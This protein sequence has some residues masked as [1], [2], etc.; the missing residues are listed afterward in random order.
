MAIDRRVPKGNEAAMRVAPVVQSPTLAHA[1]AHHDE[2]LTVQTILAT[3]KA[4]GAPKANMVRKAMRPATVLHLQARAGN[5]A[6]GNL[7][8]QRAAEPKVSAED[9]KSVEGDTDRSEFTDLPAKADSELAKVPPK[10]DKPPPKVI[11]PPKPK[12]PAVKGKKKTRRPTKGPRS[13]PKGRRGSAGKKAPRKGAGLVGKRAPPLPPKYNF[14][15][16]LPAGP[17]GVPIPYPAIANPAFKKVLGKNRRAVKGAHKHPSGKQESANAQG[18]ALAPAND[19]QAQAK[20]SHATTM[21]TAKPKPFDE[22]AFV[23]AVEAAITRAAPRNLAEAGKLDK[24]AAGMKQA[25]SGTVTSAK[26][27]AAGDVD[28]KA[29]RPLDPSKAIKKPVEPL[30]PLQIPKPGPLGAAAAMPPPVSNEMVDMRHGPATVDQNMADA[31]VDEKQLAESNEPEFAGA[32]D[33]KKEATKH[34]DEAPAKIRAAEAKELKKAQSG[35]SAAERAALGKAGAKIGAV[36]GGVGGKKTDAKSKDE[37]ARKKVADT[38]NSIYD[39]TKVDV[40]KVLSGLSTKV[41][42]QFTVGEARVRAMFTSDWKRRLG[43]YKSRRYSGIR[44]KYRWVRDKFKGLPAAANDLFEKSRQI[45]E[46]QMKKLVRQMAKIVSAELQRA[47]ARIEAGRKQISDYVGSLKGDLAKVGQEAAA[48]IAEKFDDLDSSVKDTFDDLANDLGKKYAE[49]RDAV[50]AEIT[51]A[52]EENKG[53]IDKAIDKVKGAIDTIRKLKDMLLNVL[54]KISDVVTKIIKSPIKFL[55]N[56]VSAVA[57]GVKRFA[58]NIGDHLQKGLMGW[59]LGKLATAGVDLPDSF[60]VKSMLKLVMSVIG[61]SIGAI[62]EKFVKRIGG[63]AFAHLEKGASIVST[64]MTKGPLAIIDQILDKVSDFEDMVIGKIKEFVIEKIVRSGIEFILGLLNPAAAFIKACKMIYQIVMFFVERGSEIKEFVESVIDAAGDVARGGMGGVPQKIEGVLAKVLPLAISF[65]AALLNLG[66]VGKKIQAIIGRVTKPIHKAIDKIIDGVLKT[67]KPIWG[68][69]A[70]AY[71]KGMKLYEKGKDKAKAAY[72]KGKAKVASGVDKVKGKVKGWFTRQEKPFDMAGKKHTLIAEGTKSGD[73]KILMRSKE[74]LLSAKIDKAIRTVRSRHP[75]GEM[76]ENV[77]AQIEQLTYIRGQADRLE[78]KAKSEGKK[79]VTGSGAPPGFAKEMAELANIISDHAKE[80]GLQDIMVATTGAVMVNLEI[81]SKFG[82]PIA[83]YLQAQE[84]ADR[85]DSTIEVRPTTGRA[86]HL[87]EELAAK[88]KP[89]EIKAKTINAVDV[90]LGAPAEYLGKAAWFRPE[91]PSNKVLENLGRTEDGKRRADNM[92]ARYLARLAEYKAQGSDLRQRIKEGELA[93]AQSFGTGEGGVLKDALDGLPYTGDFDV[94]SVSNNKK[95]TIKALKAAPFNVQHGAHTDWP[96]LPKVLK[97]GGLDPTEKYI[98]DTIVKNHAPGGESLLRINPKAP[99][100]A[101]SSKTPAHVEA[102]AQPKAPEPAVVKA[103]PKGLAGIDALAKEIK[104]EKAFA[105][106][107]GKHTISAEGTPPVLMMASKKDRLSNKIGMTVAKLVSMQKEM[108]AKAPP[109]IAVQISTL[110]SIGSAAKSTQ[111]ALNELAATTDAGARPAVSKRVDGLMQDLCRRCAE[112]G[113]RFSLPDLEPEKAVSPGVERQIVA[114]A[115][116]TKAAD[117]DKDKASG[118]QAKGVFADDPSKLVQSPEFHTAA[119]AF[120]Q[121]L[122]AVA[123]SNGR[124]NET[125]RKMSEAA[126][127]YILT[128]AKVKWDRNNAILEQMLASIGSDNVGWSGSV[129][130]EIDKV[131]AV[132]D[133]GNLAERMAHLEA[134]YVE[135][136]GKDVA[137][138]DPE[139]AKDNLERMDKARLDM[140]AIATRRTGAKAGKYSVI[141]T[142]TATAFAEGGAVKDQWHARGDYDDGG[143]A[144]SKT[145]IGETGADLSP[146]EDALHKTADPA[147]DRSQAVN[148]KEGV[149]IWEMNERDKW[150]AKHRKLSIPIGAGPSGTTNKCMQMERVLGV[151]DAVGARLACIGYLLPARH[152]TLVEVLTGAAAQG[153]PFTSGP[154]MYREL[155]PLTPAELKTCG[156]GKFPDEFLTEAAVAKKKKP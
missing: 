70:K 117:T 120:E 44:G 61:V 135:I 84:V 149:R 9:T 34:A 55:K 144:N 99:P 32:L 108:G 18:A 87:Y 41:D 131:M 133:S 11:P 129:G 88:P 76:P 65:L 20:G 71:K 72:E 114:A 109:T 146:R 10:L 74:E 19:T 26:D 79:Q 28:E 78:K 136:L 151:G 83:A 64:L 111:H 1:V 8:A 137:E 93:I 21:A 128:H 58:A 156:N 68:P 116:G 138:T 54:A 113:D 36:E 5:A 38:V 90:D 86:D 123:W 80:Q 27:D 105:M 106:G 13:R 85:L 104:A 29:K 98:Y 134:F 16:Q 39:K 69:V 147:W 112:Y 51:A 91:R 60:D 47:T 97:K 107:G 150:V 139:K 40:D 24:K 57:A 110:K 42:Q 94:Y 25:I 67:T 4:G 153:V 115:G 62:R 119:K 50:N 142:P 12:P 37:M 141:K 73:V 48:D 23:A 2:A 33:A 46:Q 122:G 125:A 130:K 7:L 77:K 59:L 52:Q 35:A 43:E 30:K 14:K 143:R 31:D 155:Y 154:Q 89:K 22:D 100:T 56:F 95:A 101:V 140:Q 3:P 82:L 53:L 118:R 17:P 132:F 126:K 63:P 49:S 92:Q 148:W 121:K 124:A 127:K 15:S 66:G 81:L 6:V 102:T 45:Y 103:R 75:T 145:P 96:S 152:H